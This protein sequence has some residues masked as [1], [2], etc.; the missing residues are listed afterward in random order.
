[1]SVSTSDRRTKDS[2][3][4]DCRFPGRALQKTGLGFGRK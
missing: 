1:M 3:L 2:G 4:D